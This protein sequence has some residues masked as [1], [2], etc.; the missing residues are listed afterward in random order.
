MPTKF[1]VYEEAVRSTALR[2]EEVLVCYNETTDYERTMMR[3]CQTSLVVETGN[4]E[5]LERLSETSVINAFKKGRMSCV[6][7]YTN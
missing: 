2:M 1:E 6:T 3:Q 5:G 4:G 7:R